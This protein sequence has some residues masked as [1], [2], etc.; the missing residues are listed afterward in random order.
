M[1]VVVTGKAVVPSDWIN[2]TIGF[3]NQSEEIYKIKIIIEDGSQ[4]ELLNLKKE[5]E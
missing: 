4:V 5:N 3:L 2:A 1:P